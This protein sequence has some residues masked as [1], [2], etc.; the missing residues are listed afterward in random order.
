M[1]DI[2]N[3]ACQDTVS[4]VEFADY[5]RECLPPNNDPKRKQNAGHGGSGCP[6]AWY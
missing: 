2:S 3:F 5:L 1:S 4:M 6:T